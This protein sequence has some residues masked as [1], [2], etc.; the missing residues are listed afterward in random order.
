ML[1]E[2][3]DFNAL[4]QVNEL[5]KEHMRLTTSQVGQAQFTYEATLLIDEPDAWE[6]PSVDD[7]MAMTIFTFAV[8]AFAGAVLGIA[9]YLG[10]RRRRFETQYYGDV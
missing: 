10:F 3:Q 5:V 7:E 2:S 4:R 6:P 9:I 1:H 8:L